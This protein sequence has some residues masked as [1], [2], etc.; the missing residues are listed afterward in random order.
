MKDSQFEDEKNLVRDLRY[1]NKLKYSEIATRLNRSL[2]WVHC[3]L[4]DKYKP[5]GSRVEKKFQDEE[6]RNFLEKNGHKIIYDGTRSK[7]PEFS[8]E[9]DIKS[10]KDGLTYITEIKNVVNHHQLQTAIGQIILHNYALR[11]KN[12]VVYQIVFPQKFQSWR[13]FSQEFL[14]YLKERLS[15]S[16]IFI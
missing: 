12:D 3:R 6:V 2:Y 10:S 5:A 16:I 15:I 14:D 8:Q 11:N 4:S 1:K 9:V 7:C 13:Y